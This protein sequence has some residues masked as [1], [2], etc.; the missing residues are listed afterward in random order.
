MQLQNMKREKLK[1]LCLKAN[2][3]NCQLKVNLPLLFLQNGRLFGDYFHVSHCLIFYD[4]AA[5]Q[6]GTVVS[7][8]LAQL[9]GIHDASSANYSMAPQVGKLDTHQKTTGSRQK[10][11]LAGWEEIKIDQSDIREPSGLW[12]QPQEHSC[13]CPG[14]RVHLRYR[15][16]VSRCDKGRHCLWSINVTWLREQC[17]SGSQITGLTYRERERREMDNGTGSDRGGFASPRRHTSHSTPLVDVVAGAT[18][19]HLGALWSGAS[20][21]AIRLL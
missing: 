7:N 12:K 1:S 16:C 4:L 19:S 17:W 14:A 6:N 3:D 20:W 5:V 15:V 9:G 21:M 10:C 11:W 13:P 18:L 8:C 2:T